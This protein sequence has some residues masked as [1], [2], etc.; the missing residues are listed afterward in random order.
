MADATWTDLIDLTPNDLGEGLFEVSIPTPSE[1]AGFY[2]IASIP[3][4]PLFF[5]DFESGAPGWT[6]GGS[7]D[8][9]ELGTPSIGP[10]SAFSGTNAYGT[11][12][13]G[14]FEKF[15]EAYLRSPEIDLTNVSVANLRFAEFHSVD[16]EIEFHSVVVNVID[17]S[18]NSI[19]QEVFSAAGNSG[20]WTQRTIRLAGPTVGAKVK[21]EFL[22]FSDD[23]NPLPGFYID[24]VEI[25]EN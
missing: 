16:T 4:P 1:G 19:I 8:E 9:W 20:G 17:P 24:D 3:P 18:D 10:G 25:R 15:T 13:D 11:D 14:D 22:L 12:L 23:F 21:I 2:Q 7:E 5:D 6:H